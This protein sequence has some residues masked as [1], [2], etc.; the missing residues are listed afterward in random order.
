MSSEERPTL[1]LFSAE[2]IERARRHVEFGHLMIER[3]K[4]MVERHRAEGRDSKPA[5]DLQTVFERTQQGTLRLCV[6][7]NGRGLPADF[8]PARSTGLGMR[9]VL[10]LARQLGSKLT[11]HS[12][13]LGTEFHLELPAGK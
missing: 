8:D 7:D 5:Q 2:H 12:D 11:W 13:A 1:T 3:Q 6:Y 9:L 4:K 10:V